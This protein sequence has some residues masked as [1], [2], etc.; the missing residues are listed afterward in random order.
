MTGCSHAHAHNHAADKWTKAN[1]A[2]EFTAGIASNMTFFSWLFFSEMK[3]D[4]KKAEHYA[5]ASLAVLI[6]LFFAA[7]SAYCHKQLNH[8]HQPEHVA[9]SGSIQEGSVAVAVAPAASPDTGLVSGQRRLSSWQKAALFGDACDHTVDAAVPIT[10]GIIAVSHF[11]FA[12]SLLHSSYFKAI[13]A[14]VVLFSAAG[15]YA[16]VRTCGAAMKKA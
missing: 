2:L 11:I 1:A 14:A 8:H 3:G 9:H 13:V 6:S 7:S 15:S 16:S 10:V 5:L 12:D 4:E